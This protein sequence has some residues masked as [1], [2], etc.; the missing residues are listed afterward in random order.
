[1]N[2]KYDNRPIGVFDS[3]LG[4][5]TVVAALSRQLPNEDIL[6]LGDTARVP[7]GDKSVD[8]IIRFA[9][10][11]VGFL[12]HRGVKLCV[13]AC[14]TVSAVAIDSLR[15]DRPDE[16]L[17][18]VIESGVRAAVASGARKI[19]VLGTRA[20]VNSDA[21][22]R[23]LHAVDHS[24]LIESI[25]CPLF[26]PLAEEG[27]VD[28]PIARQVFDIYLAGLKASPPDALLLGCTHYPLFQP[29]LDA[30]FGGRVRIIDSA[31][32][33]ADFVAEYLTR[34]ALAATPEKRARYGFFVTDLPSEFH[35]HAQRFLGRPPGRVDKVQLAD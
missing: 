2:R 16:P 27:I 6:Y 24:L 12:R 5:M 25:A 32:A 23:S 8:S 1:M 20:T 15:R 34:E 28:G 9:G 3:G 11:D 35:T 26:V 19:A 33:C 18:G 29:A 10:Q 22:R 4:G 17:I 31:G 21:Y 30:Y 13:A 14:N 7:Y